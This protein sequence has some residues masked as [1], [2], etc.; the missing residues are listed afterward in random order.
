VLVALAVNTAAAAFIT[1][2]GYMDAYYYFGGAKRLAQGHGFT[3]PY[4]WNY[5]DEPAGLPH[6][7]H[8]YWM[9]L[10]SIVPAIAMA[11]CGPLCR[12]NE[13]L[14]RAAQAPAVLAASALP[15]VSYL[16]ARRLA[17]DRG[18]P[19]NTAGLA[20]AW[21]TIMPGF[22]LAYWSLPDAF[23]LYGV[24]GS[25]A[26]VFTGLA[27]ERR[28]A[29]WFAAAGLMTGLG[30]LARAD[31]LLLLLVAGLFA[32]QGSPTGRLRRCLAALAGYL[33]VMLP[34][35]ARN[36]AAT[37]SMLAPG[38]TKTLW[39]TEYN[40]LFLYPAD[41]TAS[42]YFA[43][44][45]GD[46]LAGKLEALSL[47][48]QT[49]V[50]VHGLIFLAPFIVAGLWLCG[51]HPWIQPAIVYAAGLYFV[52]TLVFTFPGP[53]GGLLHSGPAL[54]P[55]YFAVVPVAV[56]RAVGWIAARRSGWRVK[57]ASRVFLA[58]FGVIAALLTLA[59]FVVRVVGTNPARPAWNQ[60]DLA[61]EAAGAWLDQA[62]DTEGIVVVNNPPAFHYFTGHPAVVVPNGGA[63]ALMAVARDFSARW[64]V[65]D[66]NVPDALR[67]VYAGTES[68]PCLRQAAAFSDA[69]ARPVYLFRVECIPPD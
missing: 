42:G 54:L 40:D 20:A 10:A 18:E 22:Y 34:W 43:A 65:L 44:G 59:V 36:L 6:P 13:A 9:P 53:R 31:G 23:G 50:A 62:G 33:A 5:L 66:T 2:P 30:H 57:K 35:L 28:S 25:L 16:V 56:Q 63:E 17:R 64:V 26:L 15:L 52:M 41:L 60:A 38:G 29:R 21:F 19:G 48:V 69:L 67:P 32:W 46:I 12:T 68:V 45:W 1:R 4:L 58:G 47:N 39:L 61:Y 3:E 8:L 11:V 14:F 51:R 27:F 55:F 49:A 37:G 7:S 24:V